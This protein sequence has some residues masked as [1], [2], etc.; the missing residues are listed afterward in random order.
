ME[1]AMQQIRRSWT[2]D[3]CAKLRTLAGKVPVRE[4]VQRLDRTEAAIRFQLWKLRVSAK[5]A[6]AAIATKPNLDARAVQ[7][8]ADLVQPNADLVERVIAP[9]AIERAVTVYQQ[10]QERD[11]SVVLQARKILTEH[12][13]GLVD[14]G[15]CDERRLTVRGLS[16]LKAVERDHPIKSAHDTPKVK[17]NTSTAMQQP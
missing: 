8:K 10:L 6:V 3:D 7:P 16:H 4:L 12:I 5:P 1:A 13:Y 17:P 11:Q 15:E 9:A 2:E 14:Q